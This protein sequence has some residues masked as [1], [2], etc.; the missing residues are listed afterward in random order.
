MKKIFLFVFALLLAL[1]GQAQSKSGSWPALSEFHGVMS[2]TFHPS[3]EGNLE[4][5]RSR[6]AEMEQKALAL[7][8]KGIPA[9]YNNDKVK[10]A[11]RRL[12]EGAKELHALVDQK[13]S[14]DVLKSKLAALHDIFHEIAG[15][16]KKENH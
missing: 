10:D 9:S 11:V 13:A 15:L 12:Q 1:A 6:A 7:T 4:P 5:I 16:C 8:G 3:E 2:Q 14:D